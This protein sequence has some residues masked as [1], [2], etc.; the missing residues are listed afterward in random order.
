LVSLAATLVLGS[1]AG[2]LNMGRDLGLGLI[3]A[4]PGPAHATRLGSSLAIAWRLQRG[5]MLAWAV[6]YFLAGLFVGNVASSGLSDLGGHT[7]WGSEFLARFA[8]DAHSN[9]SDMLLWVLLVSLG[10]TA[11]LY[12]LLGALQLHS[13]EMAGHAAWVLSTGTSRTHWMAAHIVW[14]M[15]GT[16]AIM[17][18]GGLG[19]GLSY[20]VTT[21]HGAHEILRML[22]GGLIQVPAI[23]TIGVLA[24]LAFGWLPRGA[25]WVAWAAFFYVNLFGEVI[26]P[27]LGL[28]YSAANLLVPFYYLPKLT[29]GAAFNPTPPLLL[30]AIAAVF[31]LLGLWGFSRRDLLS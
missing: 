30:L 12:A 15:I 31:S 27:L 9:F 10:Y 23:W 5:P 21:G 29:S 26:G 7:A 17:L 3:P 20:G 28:T 6:A 19:L 16:T 4:K 2:A 8:G 1:L 11:T 24:L 13:E 25:V 14:L 18:A 22:A